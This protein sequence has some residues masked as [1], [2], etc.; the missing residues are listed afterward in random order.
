MANKMVIV[1]FRSPELCIGIGFE[2]IKYNSLQF[3]LRTLVVRR[4]RTTTHTTH[5]LHT[6]T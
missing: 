6:Y 3:R 4:P 1:L 2:T 5:H